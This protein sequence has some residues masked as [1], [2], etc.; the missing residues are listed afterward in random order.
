MAAPGLI[1]S[2]GRFKIWQ[3]AVKQKKKKHLGW[4]ELHTATVLDIN[5]TEKRGGFFRFRESNRKQVT[6]GEMLEKAKC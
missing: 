4:R 6:W 5:G 1:Q 3:T 2:G